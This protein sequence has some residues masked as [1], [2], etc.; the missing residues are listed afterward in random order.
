MQIPPRFSK[1]GENYIYKLPKSLYGLKQA[2][3]NW[4]F[5][6]S[7]ALIALGFLNPRLIIPSSLKLPKPLLHMFWYMSTVSSLQGLAQSQLFH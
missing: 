4:F 2:S 5:K 6:F 1:Q 7:N 3:R